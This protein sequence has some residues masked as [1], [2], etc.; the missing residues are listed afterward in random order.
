[1]V[2]VLMPNSRIRHLQFTP[3]CLSKTGFDK[4]SGAAHNQ[5]LFRMPLVS[6]NS[7]QQS[8]LMIDL[9]LPSILLLKNS[10]YG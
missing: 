3:G 10:S 6:N 5:T 2:I 7:L 8:F 9:F 1:M 4:L